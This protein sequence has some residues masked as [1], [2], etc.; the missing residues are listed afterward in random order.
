MSSAAGIVK[1]LIAVGVP[2]GS[3][4]KSL[5]SAFVKLSAKSNGT[6]SISAGFR[7]NRSIALS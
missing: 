5:L 2:N 7:E 6:D 4:N 3:M 1:P